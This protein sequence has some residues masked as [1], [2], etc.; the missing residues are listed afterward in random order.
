MLE[1]LASLAA[2]ATATF[3]LLV[4]LYFLPPEDS[5]EGVGYVLL[6]IVCI[7][8]MSVFLQEVFK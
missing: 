6:W 1:I 7:L 2:G 5:E 8:G 4:L 3:C